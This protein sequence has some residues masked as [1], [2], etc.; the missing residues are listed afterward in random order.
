MIGECMQQGK[1]NIEL[2]KLQRPPVSRHMRQSGWSACTKEQFSSASADGESSSVRD[3]SSLTVISIEDG[4]SSDLS[5]VLNW[6]KMGSVSEMCSVRLSFDTNCI[7][8]TVESKLNHKIYTQ[9]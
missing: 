5:G 2:Y 6:D 9:R 4:D 7:A 1:R 8:E 3:K